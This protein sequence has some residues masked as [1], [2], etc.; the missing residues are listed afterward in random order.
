MTKRMERI[1]WVGGF[2]KT[3]ELPP[4]HKAA[5]APS[6]STPEFSENSEHR[7]SLR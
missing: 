3:R 1:E 4:G 7:R 2:E 6:N 5:G